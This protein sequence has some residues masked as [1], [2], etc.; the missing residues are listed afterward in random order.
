MTFISLWK[1]S[2]YISTTLISLKKTFVLFLR[3]LYGFNKPSE[4]FSLFWSEFGSLHTICLFNLIPSYNL[5]ISCL[6]QGLWFVSRDMIFNALLLWRWDIIL[7]YVNMRPSHNDFP[8]TSK[9][10]P[11]QWFREEVV[12]HRRCFAV[13]DTKLLLVHTILNKKIPDG[14]MPWIICAWISAILLHLN[15]TF[16][17]LIQNLFVQSIALSQNNIN[18]VNF[19]RHILIDCN[20]F[21]FRGYFCVQIRLWCLTV[22]N[23]NSTGHTPS[24]AYPHDL[25]YHIRFIYPSL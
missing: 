9:K 19:V 7:K 14:N 1:S 16:I 10:L 6:L 23:T 4:A 13:L 25:I 11:L 20:H 22:D 8:E 18:H 15:C 17:V 12:E 24:F 5:D 2:Q 21:W 3:I